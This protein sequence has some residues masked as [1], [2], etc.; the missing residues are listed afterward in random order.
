MSEL[1]IR[2]RNF[3]S[4][5]WKADPYDTGTEFFEPKY[6]RIYYENFRNQPDEMWKKTFFAKYEQ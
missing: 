3:W 1:W 5:M 2:I 4:R 6:I